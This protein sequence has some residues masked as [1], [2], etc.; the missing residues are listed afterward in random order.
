MDQ[1]F[2]RFAKTLGIPNETLQHDKVAE[3]LQVVEYKNGQEYAP[4]HDFGSDGLAEQRYATLLLYIKDPDVPAGGTVHDAGGH[5][6]WP[7]AF[8]GRGLTA[9]PPKGSG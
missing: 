2:T 3:N 9:R 7:K 6:S 1:I 8:G 5:T 4:H